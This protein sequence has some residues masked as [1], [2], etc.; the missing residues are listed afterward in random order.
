[1]LR[2]AAGSLTGRDV[3]VLDVAEV[4]SADRHS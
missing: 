2:D 1:M 4:L 3:E